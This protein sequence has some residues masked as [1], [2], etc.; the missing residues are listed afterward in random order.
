MK[1]DS[2]IEREWK[3][4]IAMKNQ[5]LL[6]WFFALLM[7]YPLGRFY[8][9]SQRDNVR[10]AAVRELG[11][12]S[13]NNVLFLRGADANDAF[14]QRFQNDAFAVRKASQAIDKSNPLDTPDTPPR[15]FDAVTGRRGMEIGISNVRWKHPF[16]AEVI[17]SRFGSGDTYTVSK[18]FHGWI[19]T[20]KQMA[21]IA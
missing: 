18:T 1:S 15:L 8:T 16:Q 10:E 6:R 7:L 17:I 14:L 13:L 3:Q 5:R 11:N 20:Q 21:W 9:A 4:T 19:V 2:S 12:S